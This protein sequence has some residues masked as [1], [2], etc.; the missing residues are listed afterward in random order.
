MDAIKWSIQQVKRAIII[1]YNNCQVSK[2]TKNYFDRNGLCLLDWPGNFPDLNPIGEVWNAM[3]KQACK[4]AS[5]KLQLFDNVSSAWYSIKSET[6]M[7]LYDKI[8][9]RVKAVYDA[10]GGPTSY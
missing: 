10:K 5:R 2:S 6:I 3:K 4:E 1:D 9:R 8:P 7:R